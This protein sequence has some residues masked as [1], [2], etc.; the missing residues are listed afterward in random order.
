M[1]DK[2]TIF[3]HMMAL[4]KDIE[5]IKDEIN[6]YKKQAIEL[7][8]IEKDPKEIQEL[9]DLFF[10]DDENMAIALQQQYLK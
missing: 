8:K 7:I 6:Q 5:K 3:N 1:V 4:T 10:D 2:N 9:I